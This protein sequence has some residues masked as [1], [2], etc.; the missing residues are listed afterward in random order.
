MDDCGTRL[1]EPSQESKDIEEKIKALKP[2]VD[3]FKK[4]ITTTSVDGDPEEKRRRT[5]LTRY[6]D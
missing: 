2:Q 6:V 4:A 1:I 5:E 3:R